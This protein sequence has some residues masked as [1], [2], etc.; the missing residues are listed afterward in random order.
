MQEPSS[1]EAHTGERKILSVYYSVRILIEFFD[2]VC[3][4]VPTMACKFPINVT[5]PCQG[6]CRRTQ[7]L[8]VEAS[9]RV[10]YIDPGY[11]V[12]IHFVT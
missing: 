2:I 5:V 12:E 10:G 11:N 8:V 7:L 9:E 6:I 1:R 4:N 3:A